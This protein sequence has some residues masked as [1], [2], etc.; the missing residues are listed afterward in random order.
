[1][2]QESNGQM[3]PDGVAFQILQFLT[4]KFNFTF[5]I[6]KPSMNI[7]GSTMDMS[8]SLIELLKDNVRNSTTFNSS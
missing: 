8:G 1:M 2:K 5:E 3:V 4:K 6:I 7:Y